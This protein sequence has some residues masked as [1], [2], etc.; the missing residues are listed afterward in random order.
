MSAQT[1][2]PF[3]RPDDKH[4]IEDGKTFAPLF[5][6]DGLIPAIITD[7]AS[8]GVLMFAHMNAEALRLTIETG[9][10]HFF[11]R[12]RQRLWRKGEDSG[13]RLVVS[14][15]LTDCDQDVVWIKVRIE[16]HGA[17]CHTGRLSCFYRSVD[18]L[19]IPVTGP[20]GLKEVLTER[21][22]DPAQ[23]YR[24]PHT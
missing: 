13:N 3:R 24:K 23:V 6:A 19:G 4:V 22:F 21:A 5:D 14:E 16:G 20:V 2:S 12:S 7:A 11:S 15:L 18:G 8:G 9:Q 10:V 17:A 1:A